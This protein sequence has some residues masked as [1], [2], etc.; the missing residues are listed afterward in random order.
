MGLFR[1]AGLFLM[2]FE[3]DSGRLVRSHHNDYTIDEM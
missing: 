1:G 3:N 2:R